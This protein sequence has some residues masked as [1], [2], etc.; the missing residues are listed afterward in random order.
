MEQRTYVKWF[1]LMLTLAM[2][3]GRAEVATAQTMKGQTT[4]PKIACDDLMG[5]SADQP[6]ALVVAR[7][8]R[9]F[10]ERGQYVLAAERLRKQLQVME[11]EGT[12][13]G[14]AALESLLKTVLAHI[15][16]LDIKTS[17]DA[18]VFVDGKSVG[19]SS[20]VSAIFVMP[21]A[22]VIEVRH[23]K[24]EARKNIEV[25]AGKSI[26]VE[27]PVEPKKDGPPKPVIVPAPSRPAWQNPTM[28]AGG[29]VG[30]SGLVLGIVGVSLAAKAKEDL[31]VHMTTD[32]PPGASKCENAPGV[33][34]CVEA[35]ELK[36]SAERAQQMAVFG[37][38]FAGLGTAALATAFFWPKSSAAVR[39]NDAGL[40]LT[41]V[42]LQG[43]GGM[44]LRGMF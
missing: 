29:I 25:E 26:V 6:T 37:F 9:C 10:V 30:A 31:K 7:V 3:L 8:A 28:L 21:G 20:D 36:A 13:G 12:H 38:V 34:R 2:V 19:K 15:A 1:G 22:H 44:T 35:A 43:G 33:P 32:F 11:Q 27:I 4:D 41:Y 23:D 5:P 39:K 40:V 17:R 18:E 16:T 14:R 42:P 24:D